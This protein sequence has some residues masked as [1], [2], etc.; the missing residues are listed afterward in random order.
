MSLP[1]YP[2]RV[3]T[4][5]LRQHASGGFTLIEL[6][7]TLGIVVLATGLVMLRYASFNSSVLLTSQ[8]Y[9]VAFDLR[10]TQ[11]LAVSVR[12][13][14][15]VFRQEYGMHFDINSPN[16]YLL[17]QDSD[18]GSNDQNLKSGALFIEYDENE[19]LGEPI[20][21]DPRFTI[22]DLCAT[23]MGGGRVCY[24]ENNYPSFITVAFARPDFDAILH[25]DGVGQLSEAEIM[26]APGDG[27][28][29]ITRSVVINAN[30]QIAVE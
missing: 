10:E 1:S 2:S 8:A 29:E 5:V 23:S 19:A 11:S 17:M 14:Q 15:S 12:G 13:N 26:F 4:K 20:I 6:M 27:Q 25:G 30:G 3:Q 18:G 28:G 9:E 21:V 7:V 22:V 24:S 16:Q